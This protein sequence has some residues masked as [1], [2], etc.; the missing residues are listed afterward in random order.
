[1]SER[2]V[3][4]KTTVND[5]EVKDA[6]IIFQSVWAELEEEFGRESLLFPRE[7]FWLNGAPGA[8][9]GTHTRFVMQ[10]RDFTTEPMVVSDLLQSPEARKRIDAGMLVGDREVTDL[11][12]RKLLDPV[13]ESGAIVD[14]Y[15]R[16][17]VQVECL[18]LFHSKLHELRREF[19]DTLHANRFRKPQFHI[20]VLFIDEAESV[21]RQINRG[22]K[23]IEHNQEVEESG[24]GKMLE[25]RKTDLDEDAARNRYRTFK[26]KTYP[27]LKSL[28]NIFYYH[29]INAHGSIESVEKRILRELKYQ[30]TLE[31]DTQTYDKLSIIPVA[32]DIAQHARQQLVERLEGYV[33][34]EPELF[35]QIVALVNERFVPTIKRHAITG[36]AHVNI[37]SPL[38]SNAVALAMLIDIFSERG[39]HA[40]VDEH[41][42]EIPESIDPKT[43]KITTR[44]KQVYRVQVNFPGSEIRRG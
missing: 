23:A 38:L 6:Q 39:F 9:K 36:Q 15:P 12:F 26:E 5:L 20:L 4:Q 14:G 29:F 22:L 13:Y 3:Q 2:V 28:R 25:V 18:K 33:L 34:R 17:N 42:I 1:M 19:R 10:Y 27:A 7:I 8:G 32:H 21:K 24:V 43:F 37:E 31:L 30:S 11:V 44:T 41:N 16:S 40:I 35:D